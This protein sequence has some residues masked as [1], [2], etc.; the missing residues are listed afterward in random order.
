M[1]LELSF[2]AKEKL[3]S[4]RVAAVY[5]FGSQAQGLGGRFSDYD[6]GVLL[7]DPKLLYD[8]SQ[9]NKLYDS[10]LNIFSEAIGQ[11]VNV[12]IV[13]L[14]EADLVLKFHVVRFGRLIFEADSKRV[15]DF[16][17][18]VLLEHADFEPYRQLF[19]KATLGRLG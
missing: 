5:L 2:N 9:R 15:L 16:R 8:R 1:P 6:L 14:D 3:E 10:L 7:K 12:D 11:P 17:H 19:E 4:L 13:F 18:N